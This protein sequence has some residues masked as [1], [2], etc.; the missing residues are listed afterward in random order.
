[1]VKNFKRHIAIGDVHGCHEE[2]EELLEKIR[3]GPDDEIVML[4]DL[5]NH[6]PDGSRC[7]KLAREA[8]AICLLGN[9]ELRLLNYR[10]TGDA[11]LLKRMDR[12]TVRK[13]TSDDWAQIENMPLH[14]HLPELRTVF[15]HAGFLPDRPWETQPAE[16]VTQ[17]QVIDKR[18]RPR[19]RSKS[20]KSPHWSTRW[21]GPP[22]VVYGHTPRPTCFR[23]ESSIGIDTACV[24]GGALTAYILPTDEIIQVPA[25]RSYV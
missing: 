4:G 16:I 18:G 22:F 7:L 8:N 14:H 5:V 23:L 21:R 12:K 11:K 10:R 19:K 9:H 3:P 20:P 2:L 24:Y 1:M 15:V 6:G 25:H 13:L 17:I